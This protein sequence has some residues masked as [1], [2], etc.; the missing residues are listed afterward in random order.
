MIKKGAL[1][2]FVVMLIVTGIFLSSEKLFPNSGRYLELGIML[3]SITL[4]G[5]LGYLWKKEHGKTLSIFG[6][7]ANMPLLKYSAGVAI[8]PVSL[9]LI[10]MM[11]TIVEFGPWWPLFVLVLIPIAIVSGALSVATVVGVGGWFYKNDT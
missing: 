5:V 2:G 8:W 1:H 3:T 7:V 4:F 6:A 11:P 10:L 9:N